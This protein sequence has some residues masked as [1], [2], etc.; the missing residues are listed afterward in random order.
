MKILLIQPNSTNETSK[1]FISLQYPLNLAYIASALKE[2]GNDISMVDFNVT[3]IKLLPEI[4]KKFN[5]EIVGLTA[6]TPTIH[7]AKS[8]IS[9]IKKINPKIITILG[10]VH[11]SALPKETMED[12]E[13]LDYLVFGE[14]EKTAVE[15]VDYIRDKRNLSKVAGI[16]F[17][18]GNKIIKN[19]PREL[20]KDLNTIL[21][22]SKDILPLKLYEKR[23]VSRGFS[24]EHLKIMELMTSRG[25]PNKCIFC[26]GHINYGNTIRFRSYD[27]IISEIKQSIEK[28]G[29]THI[30]F[31]DD[32]FTLNRKLVGDLCKFCKEHKLTWD[33][34]AR[35]NTVNYD[36]LKIMA[37]S[38]C[39]KISFGVESGNSEILKKIK[40]N[41]TLPQIIKTVKDAKKTGIRY[42]ECT[43]MI[44]SCIEETKEDI[45]DTVKLIYQLMPDFI[46]VSIMCPF[47]GT[48][49]YNTMLEKNLMNKNPDWSQF[50]VLGNLKRYDRIIN[51][52]SE[53]MSEIQHKILK[54]YYSS[55]KYILLQLKQL[56]TLDEIKYFWKMGLLYLNE[57]LFKKA[58]LLNFYDN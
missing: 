22:P 50:S 45:K 55:P 17:R 28:Y 16:L 13:D 27:N 3:D 21:F 39:K 29:I 37:E 8:I 40:K 35:V 53:E 32:T 6:M 56:R 25:C 15:L 54:D 33:C 19:N 57:F 20:I 10:G 7:F 58:G 31:L 1:E 11:A 26:A 34:N 18:K 23:H 12:I 46:A 30:S 4:I 47:P 14:G 42:V 43:F 9:E 36:F 5:P 38:G 44:G 41:I 52:T 48:E 49:I 51:L 2:A 24:R